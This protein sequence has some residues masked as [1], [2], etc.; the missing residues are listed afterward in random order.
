MKRTGG[1]AGVPDTSTKIGTT[2]PECDGKKSIALQGN[3][4]I[5]YPR[6][7]PYHAQHSHQNI[8]RRVQLVAG[9]TVGIRQV[10]NY[11]RGSSNLNC[12]NFLQKIN[13]FPIPQRSA[14][15]QPLT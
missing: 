14:S 13:P 4:A 12:I 7:A 6:V 9:L 3:R 5:R 15:G 2:P 1:G 10:G 8:L 11:G